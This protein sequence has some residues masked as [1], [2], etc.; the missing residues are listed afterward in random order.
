MLLDMEVDKVTFESY[1]EYV[2]NMDIISPSQKLRRD[3]KE[4]E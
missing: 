3:K 4:G 2:F 1:N